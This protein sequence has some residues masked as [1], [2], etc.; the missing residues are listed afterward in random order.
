MKRFLIQQQVFSNPLPSQFSSFSAS[1]FTGSDLQTVSTTPSDTLRL[2]FQ[3]KCR[4]GSCDFEA[5]NNHGIKTIPP[6]K[7][8]V[9]DSSAVSDIK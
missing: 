7:E 8:Y 1:N 6:P 3:A 5:F 9:L 2:R 4:I